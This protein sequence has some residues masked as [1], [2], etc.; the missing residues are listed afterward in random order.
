V[1]WYLNSND[2]FGGHSSALMYIAIFGFVTLFGVWAGGMV[3]LATENQK[4]ARYHDDIE[5]GKFLIMLDVKAGE[6]ERLKSL[7]AS[8]HPE[9]VF[10]R[11]GSTFVN[12]FKFAH[13]VPAR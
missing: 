7:M 11:V 12:P 5:A 13:S 9:A 2:T 8:S 1:A 10:Q 4:I 6:E 3:G